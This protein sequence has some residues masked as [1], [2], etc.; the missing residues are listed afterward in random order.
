MYGSVDL[1]GIIRRYFF[2]GAGD[3][4]LGAVGGAIMAVFAWAILLV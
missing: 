2:L 4:R 3:L 1:F